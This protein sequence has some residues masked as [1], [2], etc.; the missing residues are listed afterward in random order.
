LFDHPG[1]Q[2]GQD[3]RGSVFF[4][5]DFMPGDG[6]NHD[7]GAGIVNGYGIYPAGSG[8]CSEHGSMYASQL[9][10]WGGRVDGYQAGSHTFRDV[11]DFDTV[12]DRDNDIEAVWASVA[13]A[14]R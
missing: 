4:V 2:P 1:F 6:G 13:R 14:S 3:G 12:A 9:K 10:R 11:M 7:G 5:T 8:L